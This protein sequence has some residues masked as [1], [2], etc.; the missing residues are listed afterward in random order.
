VGT[1]LACGAAH[2]C[3]VAATTVANT[4]ATIARRMFIGGQSKNGIKGGGCR[5]DEEPRSQIVDAG[6]CDF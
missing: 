4:M 2:G 1:R 6:S 3:G 5:C